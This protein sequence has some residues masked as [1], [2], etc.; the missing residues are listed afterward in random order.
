M[1]ISSARPRPVQNIIGGAKRVL[2]LVQNNNNV[3]VSIGKE[4]EV[5]RRVKIMKIWGPFNA[6][7]KHEQGLGCPPVNRFLQYNVASLFFINHFVT[8]KLGKEIRLAPSLP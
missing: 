1:Y 6:L 2:E 7:C 3:L 5:L 4:R 8:R